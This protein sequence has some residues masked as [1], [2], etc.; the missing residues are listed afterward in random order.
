MSAIAIATGP[1]VKNGQQWIF[2]FDWAFVTRQIIL[3]KIY[4]I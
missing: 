1:A 2:G 4:N 3:Q